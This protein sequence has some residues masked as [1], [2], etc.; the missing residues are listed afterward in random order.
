MEI[1][2]KNWKKVEKAQHPFYIYDNITQPF[3]CILGFQCYVIKNLFKWVKLQLDLRVWR[4]NV[5]KYH[6]VELQDHVSCNVSNTDLVFS[7]SRMWITRISSG[8]LLYCE[9]V[10]LHQL[11]KKYADHLLRETLHSQ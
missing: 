11:L 8:I 3:T 4:T 7:P 1:G 6:R 5:S 9:L 2:G 10:L